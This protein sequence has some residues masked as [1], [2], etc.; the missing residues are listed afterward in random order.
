VS[1]TAAVPNSTAGIFVDAAGAT[2][3]GT[4]SGD[5]NVISGNGSY[6]ISIDGAD[7]LV[8]GNEIG[9]DA[10][11]TA[12]VPNSGSGISVFAAGAT[13]GAAGAGNIIAFN[14]GPGVATLPGSSGGTIRFNAIFSNGGP[15]ID[16]NE[17]GVTPNTPNG[18]N[19]TPILVSA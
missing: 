14:G 16:R 12:A 11:G 10:G 8:V 5:A 1:G 2:I 15:G 4:A 6:G 18:A 3:G 9:T 17:D 7:C 13:I 19:N